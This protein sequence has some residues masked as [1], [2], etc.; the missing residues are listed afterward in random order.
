MSA[1][2]RITRWLAA[3]TAIIGL[4]TAIYLTIA[5]ITGSREMC[6]EGIGDCWSVNNSIYSEFLGIP[7][8]I[9]GAGA[10]LSILVIMWLETKNA[11]WKTNAIYFLFAITL[12]G[13]LF[14]AYLTYVEVA[15]LNA[16]CPF[17]VV[18]AIAMVVLFAIVVNRLIKSQ[19]ETNP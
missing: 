6:L 17:C 4:L 15:I 12:M 18:S 10:Y 9:F 19:A 1:Q 7:V 16:I 11:F 13:L 5:K 2:N 3:G 8:A 14:S